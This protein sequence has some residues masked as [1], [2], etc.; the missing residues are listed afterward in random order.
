MG[1][2]KRWMSDLLVKEILWYMDRNPMAN[3]SKMLRVAGRLVKL[4]DHK[5]ILKAFH[6]IVHDPQNNWYQLMERVFTEVNP[7]TRRLL[8][9]NFIFNS[10]VMASPKKIE[11]K[12]KYDC[13]IPWAIL[14]D[15]TSACNLKC[16]GCWASEYDKQSS[17][18]FEKLDDIVQQG[19]ELGIY[20]YIYSG[21]EPTLRKKDIIALAEK[22]QDCF[23]LAF[24]NA[25]LIDRDYARQLARVGN[26]ALAISIEGFEEETDMRRGKGTYQK[27]MKAMDYLREE[28]VG[29]GFSTCYHRYNSEVVVSDS[30]VDHLID[31]GCMF[32]WYFTYMPIGQNAVADLL[33]TPEQR[34]HMYHR[35]RKLRDE[36]PCFLIDFWNDGEFVGG[37]IAGGRCYLHIN[38]EGD[39]E[40]CAFIHYSNVN[41]REA[42]L[43]EALQSPLF[44]E[45]RREQPFNQNHLRPCPCLDNPDKLKGMVI[46]SGAR[47]TQPIDEEPVEQLTGK[48]REAAGKWAIVAD[49]LWQE[50]R[51]RKQEREKK[52][53]VS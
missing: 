40:P 1:K 33:V 20:M 15:P 45:Y 32:G 9:S 42:S 11:L 31:K 10:A 27:V 17:L 44:Q 4:E 35:V 3:T 18:S 30:F 19:K 16:T 50:S 49:P 53:I 26:F 43:L 25:T 38:A 52:R 39:V 28:G 36:N 5:E 47:S 22:H 6:E 12:K 2:V 37:C 23:F 24:T 51:R 46:R 29:F 8:I 14:M 13:N 21:G 41:I 34:E 48:C 7:K